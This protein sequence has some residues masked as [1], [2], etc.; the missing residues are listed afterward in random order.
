VKMDHGGAASLFNESHDGPHEAET[1]DLCKENLNVDLQGF[2]LLTQNRQEQPSGAHQI[3]QFYCDGDE[4]AAWIIE[5]DVVIS[6]DKF[7]WLPLK[8]RS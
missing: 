8:T 7:F 4:I 5:K 2:R 6:S 3:E 1:I